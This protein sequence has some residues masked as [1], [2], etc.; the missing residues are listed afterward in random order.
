[1]GLED[2]AVI[3]LP[4]GGARAD[5]GG[6]FVPF[7]AQ[8]L[9][10]RAVVFGVQ[11]LVQVSEVLFKSCRT[12]GAYTR[13]LTPTEEVLNRLTA[14]EELDA[15]E[16][17]PVQPGRPLAFTF[18]FIEVFSEVSRVTDYAARFGNADL[19]WIFAFPRSM[20]FGLY[21]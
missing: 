2:N 13:L 5:H 7:P 15:V 6:D 11:K 12:K 14:L 3:P 1:M 19:L 8:M 21:M 16:Q 17:P 9:L 18:E 10:K 20:T 4:S